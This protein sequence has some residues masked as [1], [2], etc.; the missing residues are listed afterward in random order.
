MDKAK[1][2][3]AAQAELQQHTWGSFVDGGLTIALGGQGIVTPGCEVCRKRIN[4]NPQ[5][6]RHLADDVLPLS[7]AAAL[8]PHPRETCRSHR[9]ANIKYKR[10]DK[11]QFVFVPIGLPNQRLRQYYEASHHQ[12][13]SEE[14]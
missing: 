5:H 4:T 11:F 14:N 7:R 12:H 1:I 2:L 10:L 13:T 8:P 9:T 3:Q 6:L